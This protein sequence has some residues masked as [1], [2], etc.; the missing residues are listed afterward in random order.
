MAFE[1]EIISKLAK[2]EEELKGNEY[3]SFTEFLDALNFAW[4]PRMLRRERQRGI[5]DIE[6][7]SEEGDDL[8]PMTSQERD[9]GEAE[10]LKPKLRNGFPIPESFES[11]HILDTVQGL[12]ENPELKD[13][14]SRTLMNPYSEIEQKAAIRTAELIKIAY[15]SN[16]GK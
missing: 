5:L 3:S 9:Y 6:R 10:D 1:E 12:S 7:I 14:L 13:I 11:H 15:P 4:H 2:V 16:W 8:A